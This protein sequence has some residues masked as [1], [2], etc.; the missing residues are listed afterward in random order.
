V[1]KENIE[2]VGVGGEGRPEKEE[3][4]PKLWFHTAVVI[5]IVGGYSRIVGRREDDE[6][7]EAATET[8]AP[9]NNTP[10]HSLH[11]TVKF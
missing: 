11:N 3:D 5:I 6:L 1:A 4:S 8:A 9:A 7:G 2:W 10:R